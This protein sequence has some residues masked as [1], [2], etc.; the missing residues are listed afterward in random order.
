MLRRLAPQND[1]NSALSRNGPALHGPAIPPNKVRLALLAEVTQTLG[2]RSDELLAGADAIAL[3]AQHLA[4][5]DDGDDA[6]VRQ[7]EQS[8]RDH[9]RACRCVALDQSQEIAAGRVL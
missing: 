5:L 9:L 1:A 3:A 7:I 8:K 2:F 6:Q 4:V